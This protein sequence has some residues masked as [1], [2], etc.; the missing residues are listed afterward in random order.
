MYSIKMFTLERMRAK[1]FTKAWGFVQGAES[2]P[3]LLGVPITGYINQVHPKAGYYFSC[4][5][6]VIG[7]LLFFAI[8]H[9]K[10]EPTTNVVTECACP[11]ITPSLNPI[12]TQSPYPCMRDLNSYGLYRQ[13]SHHYE[14]VFNYNDLPCT[15]DRNSVHRHSYRLT[16]DSPRRYLPKSISYAANMNYTGCPQVRC[17]TRDA[18]FLRYTPVCTRIRPNLRPSKSVPEGLARYDNYGSYRRP[19]YRNVQV[20]E[21]ITTS[22]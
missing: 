20:I 7:A 18:D 21:Q 2:I 10:Q 15:L 11:V 8:G 3:V 1:H 17:V 5:S 14:R 6:T 9:K 4:A 22:V 13:N 19:H 12:F 16:R